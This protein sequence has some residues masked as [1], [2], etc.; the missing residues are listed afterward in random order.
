ME[1]QREMNQTALRALGG[2]IGF[3][4]VEVYRRYI[5]KKGDFWAEE[6]TT[7]KLSL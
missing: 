6:M 3:W 4:H 5:I 1:I 2:Q 7:A